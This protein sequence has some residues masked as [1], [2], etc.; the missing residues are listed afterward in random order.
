MIPTFARSM[1]KVFALLGCDFLSTF[2]GVSHSL[3]MEVFMKMFKRGPVRTPDDFFN[4][5]LKIYQEKYSSFNRLFPQENPHTH[6]LVKN[7]KTWSKNHFLT[8]LRILAKNYFFQLKK[9]KILRKISRSGW[10]WNIRNILSVRPHP[11]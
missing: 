7:K 10:I 9:S 8:I 6:P 11:I 3:G 1:L 5:M 4:S 2:H